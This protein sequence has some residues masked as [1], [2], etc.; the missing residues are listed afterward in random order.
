MGP[1]AKGGEEPVMA[2]LFAFGLVF[3]SLAVLWTGGG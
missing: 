2:T 1:V 3:V